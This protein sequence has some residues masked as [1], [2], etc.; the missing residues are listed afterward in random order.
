MRKMLEKDSIGELNFRSSI[1]RIGVDSDHE[2]I[3]L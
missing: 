2:S 1:F 3:L